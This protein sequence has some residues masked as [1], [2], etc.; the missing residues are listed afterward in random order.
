MCVINLKVLLFISVEW[1]LDLGCT[2]CSEWFTVTY[3]FDI[4]F[5]DAVCRGKKVATN[6]YRKIINIIIS[7]R[8]TNVIAY[9]LD[10]MRIHVMMATLCFKGRS[11]KGWT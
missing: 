6:W 4:R 5:H 3:G 1:L 7:Q 10:S 2:Q 11:D 8:C 9:S